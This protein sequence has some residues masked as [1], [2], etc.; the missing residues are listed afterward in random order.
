MKRL[1][2]LRMQ[3][4]VEP[5]DIESGENYLVETELS[6]EEMYDEV[7]KI[8]RHFRKKGHE[9][10]SFEDIVKQLEAKGLVKLVEFKEYCVYA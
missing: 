1:V 3:D 5:K 8:L 9:D 4:I 7:E 10:W 2:L 6:E